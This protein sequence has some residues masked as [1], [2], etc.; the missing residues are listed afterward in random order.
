[1]KLKL[2]VSLFLL[3]AIFPAVLMAQ[4]GPSPKLKTAQVAT[5]NDMGGLIGDLA[6]VL[7]AAMEDDDV[8]AVPVTRPRI[9][10][11]QRPVTT[12]RSAPPTSVSAVKGSVEQVERDIFHLINKQR[13]AQGLE[14]LVWNEDVA[15]IARMHSRNMADQRF[16]SHRGLDGKMVNDRADSVG[17]TKWRG[18]GENIAFERG[19]DHPA[20]FAVEKWMESPSHRKNLLGQTWRESAVGVA[21]APDGSYYFTQV[22]LQRK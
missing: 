10:S 13:A 14:A 17:L 21:V 4:G 9:V 3:I 19:Y 20:A 8:V 7:N 16:F 18:I 6:A 12:V 11:R 15:K 1:M 22:F 2:S 5:G